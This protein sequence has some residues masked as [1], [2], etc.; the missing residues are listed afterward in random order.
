MGAPVAL[1][2]AALAKGRVRGVVAVDALQDAEF[3]FSGDRVEEFMRAF[4]SDFAGTCNQFIDQMFPE[5]G[6][7]AVKA[8]VRDVGCDPARGPIG[9]ALMRSFGD[10]DMER[11]FSEAGVP[12]RAINADGPNPTR[13]DTNRK[14]ADFDAVLMEGVGHY[15]HMTRP[16]A[17]NPLLMA[18]VGE[19]A[20]R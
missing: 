17:F 11:W 16:E 12:V 6:V 4:E 18:A 15:P 2:A 20:S 7:D 10:I 14:Y 13:I 9:T 1:R 3:D 8:H 19:L 5:E